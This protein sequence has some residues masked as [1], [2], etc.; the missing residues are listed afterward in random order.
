MSFNS[1]NHNNFLLLSAI[2]HFLII[3]VFT[4]FTVKSDVEFL[5]L[6]LAQI[7]LNFIKSEKKKEKPKI[8]PK[9]KVQYGKKEEIEQKKLE[10]KKE[11]LYVNN[12]NIAG[13]KPSPQYPRRALMLMQEGT[14]LLN[15][16][17]DKNGAVIK[18]DLV[19]SSG[20]AILDDAAITAVKKWK[21]R[22]DERV[23][24]SS[25]FW[26]KIPVEFLINK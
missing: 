26:V 18:V 23:K 6:D 16:L 2:L 5:K 15:A 7:N 10:S 12:A 11:I 22:P 21:F 19:K 8:S 25:Q 4:N 3:F 20:F 24:N 9:P 14:T 13:V 17:I 1:N